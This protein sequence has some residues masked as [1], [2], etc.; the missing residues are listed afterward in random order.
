MKKIL[1]SLVPLLFVLLFLSG[2]ASVNDTMDMI[3]S[4]GAEASDSMLQASEW[5][6]CQAVT[7]GAL[8]RRYSGGNK[9]RAASWQLYCDEIWASNG[10]MAVEVFESEEEPQ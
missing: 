4:N 2:C 3:G 9:N 7:V 8:R 6:V 5:G 1:V 10:E